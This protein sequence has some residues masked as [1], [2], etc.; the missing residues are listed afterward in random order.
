[1]LTF[2]AFSNETDFSQKAPSSWKF[3]FFKTDQNLSILQKL[4]PTGDPD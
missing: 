1:M 3:S 4:I 2:S